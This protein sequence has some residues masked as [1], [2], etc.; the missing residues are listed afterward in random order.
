MRWVAALLVWAAVAS[1]LGLAGAF[2]F[3]GLGV[4]ISFVSM[5]LGVMAG[6]AVWRGTTP[7]GRRPSWVDWILFGIF[8][9]ASARVFFWILLGVGDAWKIQSPNNLGD[10]ALHWQ[11][12]HYFAAG[13]PWW[14]ESPIFPGVP[15]RYPPGMNL[16]NAMLLQA[17]VPF[18]A[19][20]VWTGL[21][22]AAACAVALWRWGR[23]FAMAAFLF[24]GGLAGFA[25]LSPAWPP[26]PAEGIEWKNLFLTLFVTQRG[27]L[28][29]LPAG[30]V[31]L[32]QWRA[33][34][35]GK[36]PLPLPVWVEVLLYAMLPLFHLHTFLF[37]SLVLAMAWLATLRSTT[38]MEF[39]RTGLCALIP[40]GV[41]GWLVTGG[42]NG[43]A[44]GMLGWQPGWMQGEGG[45]QFWI[46]N[47]GLSLPV[48][49]VAVVL[50]FRPGGKSTPGDADG[51]SRERRAARVIL[52][53]SCLV[54]VLCA[55]VRFAPW[56]W[57]NTKLMIWAWLAAAPVVYQSVLA[58]LPLVARSFL[59][60][61]LFFSGVLSLADGLSARH[62]HT[63]AQRSELADAAAVLREFPRTT[64]ILTAPHYAQ[65]AALLGYPVAMGY[66]GHLWSHGYDYGALRR[67]LTGIYKGGGDGAGSALE[68]LPY[69]LCGPLE[70]GA[71]G[72]A[73]FSRRGWRRKAASGNFSLWEMTSRSGE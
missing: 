8:A 52:G 64:R 27:L 4:G 14:P 61:G 31:L 37:V 47:F 36:V 48:A 71:F 38:G 54:F 2:L 3:G 23:A 1:G 49:L 62:S 34:L 7:D 44:G 29:A 15:L 26:G 65:P 58:P 33:R 41:L 10:L 30:L 13:V 43:G 12:I 22:G 50:V 46:W 18:A 32:D 9:M 63:L 21:A 24:A 73:D 72:K 59:L 68:G 17:G 19:G 66:D 28:F 42:V 53:A 69:L 35:E 67:A 6:V 16:I 20:L 55:F 56:P 70:E 45:V 51:V 5:G 11:M 40:A 57:D 25:F 39:L 60:A